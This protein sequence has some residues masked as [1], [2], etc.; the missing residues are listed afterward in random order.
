[1]DSITIIEFD[2]PVYQNKNIENWRG[3]Y[4][5]SNIEGRKYVI[6]YKP[7]NF[8]GSYLNDTPCEMKFKYLEDY[9]KMKKLQEKLVKINSKMDNREQPLVCGYRKMKDFVYELYKEI[10]DL[11]EFVKKCNFQ[12]VDY[13]EG[14]F[15]ILKF[16]GINTFLAQGDHKFEVF[17]GLLSNLLESEYLDIYEI[18]KYDIISSLLK[19]SDSLIQRGL[20]SLD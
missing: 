5:Q 11:E 7:K 2:F 19:I 4:E 6:K 10:R 3:R 16:W 14:N 12:K 13:D 17:N 15:Y 9:Q 20:L 8:F 1:M 18:L